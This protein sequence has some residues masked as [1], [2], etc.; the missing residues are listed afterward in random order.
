MPVLSIG[1]KPKGPG[2]TAINS[3]QEA[4]CLIGSSRRRKA[5][6]S[7]V[8]RYTEFSLLNHQAAFPVTYGAVAEYVVH[9]VKANGGSSKS[10][11]SILSALRVFSY[12]G[13]FDWLSDA[14]R[15]R[16]KSV[17]Q[18]LEFNDVT[19]VQR[20][21]PLVL[22]VINR[23]LSLLNLR[24]PEGLLV[25]TAMMLA[26]NALLRTGELLSGIA[27]SDIHWNLYERSFTLV[28]IRSKAHR[29][30]GAE[31]IKCMDYEGMS[32]FKL[33]KKWFDMWGLWEH[34]TMQ[35]IPCASSPMSQAT[36]FDFTTTASRYW[37][38]KIVATTIKA[39]QLDPT[40]YSGH[41]FRAGGA[42]D[43]FVAR[44][45]YNIIKAMGR[46]K[47]DAALK[48]YRDDQDIANAVAAAFG[49]SLRRNQW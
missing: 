2:L 16:L 25:G 35:V 43:L 24:V 32:A 37:W 44:V 17:V 5:I 14:D 20:K 6:A 45:P 49:G 10:I 8:R 23:I 38:R 48:Y 22:L 39:I 26:H 3:L 33:M 27:V 19:A 12:F 15:Y 1:T 30:G 21:Q 4:E 7:I 31:S 28:L 34:P 46:W 36:R 47:S 42:T 9:F 13:E 40:M 18:L 41:S 11:G 29:K